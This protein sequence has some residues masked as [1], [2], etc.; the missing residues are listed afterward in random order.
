MLNLHYLLTDSLQVS[1]LKSIS[2]ERTERENQYTA[3]VDKILL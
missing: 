3:L 2:Q 1:L